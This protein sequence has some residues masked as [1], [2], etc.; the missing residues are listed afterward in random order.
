MNKQSMIFIYIENLKKTQQQSRH[1][2]DS[3]AELVSGL[4]KISCQFFI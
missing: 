2:F 1:S 3:V 4:I